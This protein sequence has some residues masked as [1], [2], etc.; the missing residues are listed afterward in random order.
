MPMSKSAS[1]WPLTTAARW[2]TE[3]VSGVTRALDHR[4]VGEVAGDRAHARVAEVR[5]RH[6]VEQH[7]LAQDRALA[8]RASVSVPRASS[9]RA[10][11]APRKPAPP[12]IT[13]R[14]GA[15]SEMGGDHDNRSARSPD[16]ARRVRV[17]ESGALPRRVRPPRRR[18][19][20]PSASP[21]TMSTPPAP[22]RLAIAL[23]KSALSLCHAEYIRA[24]LL[25]RLSRVRDRPAR[26]HHQGRPD[27]RPAAGQ[28]R[29]QGAVHQGD[30]GRDGRGPRRFRRALAE[31]HADGHARRASSLA[32]IPAREDPRDALVSNGYTTLAALPDGAVRRHVEPAP[33]GA[34]AREESARS[35]SSCCAATST[36]ACA[37]STRACT[38]R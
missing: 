13:M 24:R 12:V 6:D 33:R 1:A 10:R 27:P 17:L 16:R 8:P 32:T 7:E 30:R 3:S 14:M 5:R 4:R 37:S 23:R 26:H 18:P 22:K 35:T 28:P 11:R 25:A 19:S 31:G 36:P 9:A 21:P 29:R 34:A 15:S 2:N 38:T 20:P